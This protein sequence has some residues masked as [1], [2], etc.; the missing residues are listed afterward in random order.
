MK[1]IEKK[2]AKKRR[3]KWKIMFGKKSMS[4]K[5]KRQKNMS[6]KKIKKSSRH[7]L[8]QAHYFSQHKNGNLSFKS[9]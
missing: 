9:A 6:A 7:V 8:P 5:T 3:Q 1:V 4:L 2:R